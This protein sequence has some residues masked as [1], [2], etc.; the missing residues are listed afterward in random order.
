[1]TYG[2]LFLRSQLVVSFV[3]SGCVA[4]T[5]DVQICRKRGTYILLTYTHIL[6]VLFYLQCLAFVAGHP[7]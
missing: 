5:L 6:L 4:K 3:L 2:N 1:M 7:K